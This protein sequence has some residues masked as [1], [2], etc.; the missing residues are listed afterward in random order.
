MPG[1]A[2]LIIATNNRH[3]LAEIKGIFVGSNIEVLSAADFVDFPEV[4]ETGAT[5][6]ENAALKARTI[7][8]R[9]HL[10]CLA[11]DTGLEVDCLGGRPGVY[12]SRYAGP[13]ATYDDNCNKLL[14]ETA[15]SKQTDRKARFRCVMVFI[16]SGGGEHIAEG[17]IE[18]EII[19]QKRGE[20][21]FGYDPIFFVPSSGK[22]LAEME[23]SEKN[24]ISH[25]HNALAKIIPLIRQLLTSPI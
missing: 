1:R 17:T 22:T 21:G 25:R 12:S 8:Q 14:E 9:Y 13:E 11:D 18:G 19:G 4:E 5:L 23:S 10:P 3:K 2:K 15:G 16:D 6:A 20:N 7:W 24:K